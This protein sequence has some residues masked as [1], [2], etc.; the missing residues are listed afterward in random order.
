[1][2]VKSQGGKST[3]IRAKDIFASDKAEGRPNW[4]TE[5]EWNQLLENGR[6]Q[7]KQGKVPL[8]NRRFK[9]AVF[10]AGELTTVIEMMQAKAVTPKAKAALAKLKALD[11]ELGN[12]I[13]S[14]VS[15]GF[16]W[17]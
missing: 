1:M 13:Y 8:L 4:A 16:V 6:N 3:P 12:R 2:A 17:D 10:N 7:V 11:N 14:I 5:Q 15:E 9:D